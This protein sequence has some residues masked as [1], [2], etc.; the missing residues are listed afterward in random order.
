MLDKIEVHNRIETPEMKDYGVYLS[1][2]RLLQCQKRLADLSTPD[3]L[4]FQIVHQI[5]ELWMKL[6]AFTLAEIDGHMAARETMRVLTLFGR[7]HRI[8]QLMT[9]QLALLETMSP[10]DYQAIRLLLGNGSGQESPGFQL[11]LTLPQPLWARYKTVYLDAAGRSVADVYDTGYRHDDAYMVA[12]AMVEFDELFQLFRAHH[13]QLIHRSI[14]MGS[15][16]LKG[17]PVELLNA[18]MRHRFFPELWD[19]RCEM[20]DRWGAEYGVKRAS[21]SGASAAGHGSGL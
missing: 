13:I 9:D 7:V 18:G 21:I 19:I 10:F 15:K 1:V 12:E 17:R 6:M 2:D 3:E 8:M 20:T 14:G 16:S 5:E 4:Q 11:L